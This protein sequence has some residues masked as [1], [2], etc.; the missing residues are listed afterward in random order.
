M[1]DDIEAISDIALDIFLFT[2][3]CFFFILVLDFIVTPVGVDGVDV[4][5][6]MLFVLFV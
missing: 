4:A 6:L 2:F 1:N 5:R 3:C